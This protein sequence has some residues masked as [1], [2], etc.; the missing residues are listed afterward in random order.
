MQDNGIYYTSLC[1]DYLQHMLDDKSIGSN[2]ELNDSVLRF[3]GKY[4]YSRSLFTELLENQ[5]T[6]FMVIQYQFR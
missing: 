3:I 6:T 1:L 4:P 2:N 5:Q